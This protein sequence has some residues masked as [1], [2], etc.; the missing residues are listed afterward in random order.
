MVHG[1][2]G[3]PFSHY[4]Y[5]PYSFQVPVRLPVL[6]KS[7]ANLSILYIAQLHPLTGSR[8]IG[9]DECADPWETGQVGTEDGG[10]ERGG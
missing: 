10:R 3:K 5:L 7:I 8:S 6:N 9:R 4:Y 2:N 1:N